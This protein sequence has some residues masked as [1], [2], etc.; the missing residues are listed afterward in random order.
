MAYYLAPARTLSWRWDSKIA[1]NLISRSW[2]MLLGGVTASIYI[3][4]DVL[5]LANAKNAAEVGIYSTAA[6]LSEVWQIF[7]VV[8]MSAV[9]PSLLRMRDA[10]RPQYEKRVQDLLDISAISGTVLA[11]GVTATAWF[12]IPLLFGSDYVGS[13]PILLVHIWSAVFIFMRAVLSKWILS[14][15][16]YIFS[17]VTQ[18]SGAVSNVLLNLWLIPA[19]GGMG[20]AWSTLVSYSV[21]SYFSLLLSSRTRPFFWRMTKSVFWILRS[22]TII[23]RLREARK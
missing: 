18:A 19:F 14:E 16:L 2:P 1:L 13:V 11:L 4:F 3:K 20:A 8:F 10:D 6:R 9:F 23:G 12:V 17:L 5:L 22:G 15:G 21:A 7:P